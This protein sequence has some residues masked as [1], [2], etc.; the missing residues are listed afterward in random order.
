MGGHQGILK[1]DFGL[2]L[3]P[4]LM[5]W[6]DGHIGCHA[7]RRVIVPSDLGWSFGRSMHIIITA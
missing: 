1:G 5:L 7:W 2:F 4:V 6:D 3:T